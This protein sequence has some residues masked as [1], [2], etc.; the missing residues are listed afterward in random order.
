MRRV[1]GSISLAREKY[2]IAFLRYIIRIVVIPRATPFFKQHYQLIAAAVARKVRNTGKCRTAADK[3]RTP[4]LGKAELCLCLS[5]L[6]RSDR[7]YIVAD[8][9]GE[10]IAL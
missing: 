10:S 9:A 5:V 8:V 1:V 2:D 7:N 4:R 3:V 6:R